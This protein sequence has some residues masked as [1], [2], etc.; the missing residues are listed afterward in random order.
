MVEGLNHGKHSN[1]EMTWGRGTGLPE[2]TQRRGG[3][4]QAGGRSGAAGYSR[5]PHQTAARTQRA[6]HQGPGPSQGYQPDVAKLQAQ[7]V[8]LRQEACT[9]S[10]QSE[11][12][13]KR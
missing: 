13:R 7:E 1:P 4:A 8:G 12:L 5:W 3:S 10:R 2:M 11:G 9:P 6:A